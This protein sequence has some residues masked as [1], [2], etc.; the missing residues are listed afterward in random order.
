GLWADGLQH[1]GATFPLAIV[2]QNA[3]PTLPF[4]GNDMN[5][6]L[7]TGRDTQL[8]NLDRFAALEYH[9]RFYSG[10]LGIDV[11]GYLVN[12]LLGFPTFMFLPP[13]SLLP[14]GARFG[15]NVLS[16]RAGATFD[17]AVA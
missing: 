7:H 15:T 10:R 13:S 17:G 11:K 14:G 2:Q 8:T 3:P 4:G 9:D 1:R 12:D 5:D 16:Y 6:P